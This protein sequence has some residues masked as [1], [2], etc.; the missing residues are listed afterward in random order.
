MFSNQFVVLVSISYLE[1]LI[2]FGKCVKNDLLDFLRF[3]QVQD[4][5]LWTKLR[6]FRLLLN[7]VFAEFF[8]T[9]FTVYFNFFAFFL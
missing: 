5:V 3:S 9:L 6:Y 4:S 1:F 7:Y 8:I 2:T